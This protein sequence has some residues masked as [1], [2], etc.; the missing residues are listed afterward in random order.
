[1]RNHFKLLFI[2]ENCQITFLLIA[3]AII[4]ITIGL[5]IG[6]SDNP[7]GI[8]IL[9]AGTILLMVSFIHIWKKIWPRWPR[10]PGPIVPDPVFVVL[11]NIFFGIAELNSDARLLSE[12]FSFFD[13]MSFIIA[14][15]I[16]PSGI[17]VGLGGVLILFIKRKKSG[18]NLS[19]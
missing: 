13:A 8:I 9:Y 6:I 11:H 5:I 17:V 3:L 14:L 19:S 18:V 15:I 12:V 7:P 1:M 4:A 10:G 16:C 2:G